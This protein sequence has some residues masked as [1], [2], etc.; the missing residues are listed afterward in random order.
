MLKTYERDKLINAIIFFAQNT[1][2]CGKTKLF[3]LLF[4]LDLEHYNQTGRTIT[5]QDYYAWPLGPVPEELNKEIELDEAPIP[6]IW[7]AIVIKPEPVYIHTLLKIVPTREFEPGYFSRRELSIL[8]NIAKAHRHKTAQQMIELTHEHNGPWHK[9]YLE[10]AGLKKNIPLDS[11][12]EGEN[13]DF[14]RGKAEEYSNLVDHFK[15][16]DSKC[17]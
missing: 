12:L 16:L 6:S 13:A 11:S 14:I 15:D 10:G 7:D 4:L 1:E 5:G 8:D 17:H 9:V 2:H 3:K